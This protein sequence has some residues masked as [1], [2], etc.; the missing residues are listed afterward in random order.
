MDKELYNIISELSDDH[1]RLLIEIMEL[2]KREPE[3]AS[4]I[5]DHKEL[6]INHSLPE[7][8]TMAR[9]EVE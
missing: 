3:L 9:K 8:V 2:M 4:W 5:L 7:L 1:I 6:T